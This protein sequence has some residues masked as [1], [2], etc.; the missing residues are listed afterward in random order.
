MNIQ[1]RL[2]YGSDVPENEEGGDV[3]DTGSLAAFSFRDRNKDRDCVQP[4]EMATFSLVANS[5]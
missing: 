4:I 3:S 2:F 1:R 5:I